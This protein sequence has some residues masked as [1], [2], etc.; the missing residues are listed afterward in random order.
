M[1]YTTEFT[2]AVK[3]GRKLTM[4]EAK[5]LLEIAASDKSEKITGIRAYF[6]WVPANTMEHIVW[7]GNEKFYEYVP[8][9]KWLCGWLMDHTIS[10]NGELYWSGEETGDTGTIT[11]TDNVVSAVANTKPVGKDP[12]PLSL[13]E[14]GKMALEQLTGV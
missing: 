13:D 8:Q 10:A 14:L 5:E 4:A 2:G 3:L 6:Q 7:D 12:R 1:G 9:L 11:V